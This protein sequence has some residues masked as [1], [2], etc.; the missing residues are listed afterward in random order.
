[1][2]IR[3]TFVA[4]AGA[5][6][7]LGAAACAGEPEPEPKGMTYRF[8]NDAIVYC[9]QYNFQYDVAYLTARIAGE[10]HG[11]SL[12]LAS[13]AMADS[14]QKHSLP[15]SRSEINDAAKAYFTCRGRYVVEG[16]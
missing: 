10:E 9:D 15:A 6:L 13:E 12:A 1:M 11:I 7:L 2:N 16:P 5:A 4:A 8:A 3:K 14:V